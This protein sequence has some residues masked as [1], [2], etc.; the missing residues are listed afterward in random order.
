MNV[1]YINPFIASSKS[2]I[3]QSTG[4]DPSVGKIYIKSK[5]HKGNEVL[6]LIGLAGEIQ[7][8]VIISM[9]QIVA[10]KIAAA[11]MGETSIPEL[12]EIS[13]SAISELGNMISG[14]AASIFSTKNIDVDITPPTVF[15]GDNIELSLSKSVVVCIPLEF[16]EGNNIDIDVTYV[17]K[18]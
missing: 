1:E 17:E 8:S 6:V 15:T 2:V 16:G 3:H 10:C 9:T 7:G 12:D 18:N 13:K 4:I 11:M 5:E 14:N